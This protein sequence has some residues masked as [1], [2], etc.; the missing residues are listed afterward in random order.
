VSVLLAVCLWGLI[1]VY[2]W[3]AQAQLK[4]NVP[5][6]AAPLGVRHPA[7]SPDGKRLAF[8]LHGDLWVC[9]ADGGTAVRVTLHPAYDG[10]PAWSPDGK[11]LALSSNR[12]GSYDVFVMPAAGGEPVRKTF[13]PADDLACDWSPDGKEILF[14]S[15]R[16]GVSA[17]YAVGVGSGRVRRINHDASPAS[18]GRYAAGG[19]SIVYGSGIQQWWQV[20]YEGPARGAL[21]TV[22]TKGGVGKPIPAGPGFN[23]MPAIGRG[24]L[25]CVAV[26]DGRSG[27]QRLTSS[28]KWEVVLDGA[29]DPIGG[30]TCAR[31]TDTLVFERGGY[32]W[33]LD[34][35]HPSAP[36]RL[37]I[38]AASDVRTMPSGTARQDRGFG[39]LALSPDGKRLAVEAGGDIW[40]VS[41]DGGDATRLTATP[42]PET[43][44][45]WSPDGKR[46]AYV[47][48]RDDRTDL[49]ESVVES[50]Q[51]R[52]LT[53]DR[54]E[55]TGPAYAPDGSRIAFVRASGQK[56]GLVVLYLGV[57]SEEALGGMTLVAPGTAI[58]GF[59][60]SP[61]GRWLVYS[62][63]SGSGLADLYVVPAVGGTP[64]NLTRA[65]GR[66]VMPRWSRD[67]SFIACSGWIAPRESASNAGLVVVP[68]V[69]NAG[70]A[71]PNRPDPGVDA[72]LDGETRDGPAAQ[73]RRPASPRPQDP[74]VSA[75]AGAPGPWPFG[76][77]M[78]PADR[79]V[80]DFEGTPARVRVIAPMPGNIVCL[81]VAPD[82][83]SIL[84]A[85]SG[86][87][88]SWIG[89][90][91]SRSRAG[92]R[93][94]DFGKGSSAAM[95]PDA[96]AILWLDGDGA[97]RVLRRGAASPA[98]VGI[99]CAYETDRRR[100]LVETFRAAYRHIRRSA[101]GP[102]WREEDAR[103]RRIRYEEIATASDAVEDFC[104]TLAAMAGPLGLMLADVTPGAPKRDDTGYL[105]MDFDAD[106]AGPG[107]RITGVVE[108]GPAHGVSNGPAAGEYVHRVDGTS[109]DSPERLWEILRGMANRNVE[110]VVAP[111]P[112]SDAKE[113]VPGLRTLT[114]RLVDR[115]ADSRLRMAAQDK[116]TAEQ[117]A[118]LSSG[119]VLYVRPHG[120]GPD[121]LRRLSA[122]VLTDRETVR[123]TVMDL[124]N[125]DSSD[126]PT[127]VVR[128]F[129]DSEPPYDPDPVAG[130][131]APQ[132]PRSMP[133]VVWI[134]EGTRGCAEAVAHALRPQAHVW[135]VGSTSAGMARRLRAVRLA[136][137]VTLM[138]AEPSYMDREGRPLTGR[139]V[140][141]AVRIEGDEDRQIRAV[142]DAALEL[143]RGAPDATNR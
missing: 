103:L 45:V 115:E 52:R 55:E 110:V 134:N 135:L 26:R 59:D 32:L 64:V 1:W 92:V 39:G 53:D 11:W 129:A 21:F 138:L 65:A 23:G 136:N 15:S 12:E 111:V 137:D 76:P 30:L 34:G 3:P 19:S 46:I 29:D 128:L 71:Q 112:P 42:E 122:A 33:K 118:A 85:V 132:V 91:D 70:Y 66:L 40:T 121:E 47:A 107:L 75:S 125:L 25:Y 119:G 86:D 7:L 82:G 13:H 9:D 124:R 16:E 140:E 141:P 105:G 18:C 96:S 31:Q 109:C 100:E 95:M 2:H 38:A 48:V 28:G 139:P 67:G 5:S 87:D 88:G 130:L 117:I 35:M 61:D 123:C 94:A 126:D 49:F 14:A 116:A 60:W 84:F 97:V 57:P 24:G 56:L 37:A 10:Y 93:L 58:R 27:I 106:Y 69:R 51:E 90:S 68:V 89:A 114:L 127:P 142:V 20:R 99:V 74:P 4:P 104:S 44:P 78:P 63:P 83:R 8:S 41:V 102:S 22:E 120:F 131:S 73:R 113:P 72:G 77:P 17:L 81:D 108:D 6:S 54:D 143:A 36:V 79:V 62:G 43:Q 101:A 133:V 80:V 50:R 98:T